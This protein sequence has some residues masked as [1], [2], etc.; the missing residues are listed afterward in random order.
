MMTTCPHC[1]HT[2]E[3]RIDGLLEPAEAAAYDLHRAECPTCAAAHA[4]AEATL[5][6]L[7]APFAVEAPAP[8]IPSRA[9]ATLERRQ[10]RPL[11]QLVRYAASFAAGVLVTL[12]ITS[13]G[14][15]KATISKTGLPP[16]PLPSVIEPPPTAQPTDSIPLRRIR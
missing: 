7:Y 16:S 11:A 10:R 3:D 9:Q 14:Q 4:R 15:P 13:I 12:V 1:P 5:A 6:R 2:P 8:D